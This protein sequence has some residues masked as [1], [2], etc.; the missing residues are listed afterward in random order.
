LEVNLLVG[1]FNHVLMFNYIYLA[2]RPQLY[3][4]WRWV[5]TVNQKG[6]EHGNYRVKPEN[7]DKWM[8]L[9]GYITSFFSTNRYTVVNGMFASFCLKKTSLIDS[10]WLKTCFKTQARLVW[11]YGTR[12]YWTVGCLLLATETAMTFSKSFSL[13][14]MHYIGYREPRKDTYM[15]I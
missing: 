5:E 8:G 4:L 1:G 11:D 12:P 2:G 7:D 6:L 9:D 14:E 15:Y 13:Q 3:E 10:P